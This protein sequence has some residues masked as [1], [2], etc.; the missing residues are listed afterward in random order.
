MAEEAYLLDTN[1]ASAASYEG[2]RLHEKVRAWLDGLG[3]AAVFISAVSLAEC[4]YGLN[5]HSLESHVQQSIREAMAAYQVLPIDPDT[6]RIYGRIRAA[7]FAAYAP[8]NRRNR[9]ASRYVEDLRERTSGKE[10]GI[11]E[12]DLWIVSIAIAYNLIFVTGDR[13][14]GMRK[15]IDAANYNHRTRFWS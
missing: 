5:V 9:I 3:D 12:N 1:I 6:S 10:L 2:D 13:Q 15:I 14:G 7:L 4:E 11:Q 8:R